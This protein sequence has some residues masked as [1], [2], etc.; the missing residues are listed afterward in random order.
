M[1]ICMKLRCFWLS[2]FIS[3]F[4]LQLKCAV[5]ALLHSSILYTAVLCIPFFWHPSAS[6]C[7]RTLQ[8]S[9]NE[10]FYTVL[11][12]WLLL[13]GSLWCFSVQFFHVGIFALIKNSFTSFRERCPLLQPL[14]ITAQQADWLILTQFI[15]HMQQEC[16]SLSKQQSFVLLCGLPKRS[17][18][19]KDA[20][21]VSS[22][23]WSALPGTSLTYKTFLALVKQ[24]LFC[25]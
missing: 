25:S 24:T 11:S 13:G 17:A 19:S 21:L 9:L 12:I 22:H 14:H 1:Y 5:R 10:N 4:S 18:W 3:L 6:I 15:L 20:V 7:C 8:I 16:D 2:P 23:Y